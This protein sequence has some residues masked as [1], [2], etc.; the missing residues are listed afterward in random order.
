MSSLRFIL[1]AKCHD[2]I[3]RHFGDN[4]FAGS[5]FNSTTFASPQELMLFINSNAP[6]STQSYSEKKAA[7]LFQTKDGRA[8]G[9]RGIAKRNKVPTKDIV[10]EKREGYLLYIGLVEELP[11]TTQFCVIAHETDEGLSII[12]AFPGNYARPFAQKGQ[13]AKEYA[14]NKQFWAEHVLLRKKS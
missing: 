3:L 6:I 11:I 9:T 10:H 14:L 2:H 1:S 8:V 12:T 4:S 5:H 13:P 7:Y